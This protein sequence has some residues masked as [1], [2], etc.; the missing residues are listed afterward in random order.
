M[1]LIGASA[2]IFVRRQ[3]RARSAIATARLRSMLG[4]IGLQ[5]VFDVL[6]PHVSMTGH[7]G[8]LVIGFVV[9]FAIAPR[10]HAPAPPPH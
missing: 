6:V 4:L 2:M 5:V 7:L 8:G 1:A 3:S 9:G 10:A